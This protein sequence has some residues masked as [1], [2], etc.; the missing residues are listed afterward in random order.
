MK[1]QA[2]VSVGTVAHPSWTHARTLAFDEGE[3]RRRSLPPV[4]DIVP[5]AEAVG[6]TLA[7]DLFALSDLPRTSSSAMDGWAVCGDGPWQLGPA[8]RTGEATPR[9]ALA[10]GTARPIATGGPI[11]P[12]TTAILRAEH[13]FA[14]FADGVTLLRLNARANDGGPRRGA[15]L[16]M[17]GEEVRRGEPLLGAGTALNAPRLALAA[18]VGF[19]ELAVIARPAVDL[20]LLGDEVRT[21]GIPAEGEV[22]DAFLPALPAAMH[23][24]GGEHRS[25]RFVR[26]GLDDTVAALRQT[27]A[28][29]VIST[30]GTAHGPADFVRSALDVVGAEIVC[31][32]VA[33]RPGHPVI[34]AR[35]ADG[36][37]FLGLPGNPL[38]AFLAFASLGVPLLAGLTGR[39]AERG[40]LV[41]LAVGIDN[42]TSSTRLVPCE[43]ADGG[44]VPSRWQG[45]AMLRGLAAA[46]AVAVIPPGGALAGATVDT[47]PLPW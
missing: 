15:D 13:G 17:A 6:R 30:G 23:E 31:D 1:T 9:D 29:L 3:R 39:V 20:V 26:D 5:V 46:D 38:A 10:P 40:M 43:W 33:M 16:R 47:L 35:L 28:P 45:A 41:T 4:L 19:D 18:A 27:T 36:R 2:S 14:R 12:N 8:I 21:S 44:A 42:A 7:H 37:L 32:G 11:P 24:A 22:R 34:I 25:T